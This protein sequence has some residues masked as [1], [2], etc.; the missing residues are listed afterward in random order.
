M[1]HVTK[2]HTFRDDTGLFYRLQAD[3]EPGVLNAFRSTW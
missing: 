2:E 1:H 3:S